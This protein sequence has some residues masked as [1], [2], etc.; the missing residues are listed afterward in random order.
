M[1]SGVGFFTGIIRMRSVKAEVGK[2]IFFGR[3]FFVAVVF[4]YNFREGSMG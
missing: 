4:G 3:V 1:K 2:V